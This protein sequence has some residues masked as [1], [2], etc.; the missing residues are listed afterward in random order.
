MKGKKAKRKAREKQLEEA[1]RL[2]L[3][4]KR[5]EMRAAGIR[6]RDVAYLLSF[7]IIFEPRKSILENSDIFYMYSESNFCAKFLCN[8]L[9]VT[10]IKNVTRLVQAEQTCDGQ[11]Q[12]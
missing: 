8:I 2:A 3:I 5:R 6:C 4:Q 10:P 11:L 7:L 1:R 9:C 12:R